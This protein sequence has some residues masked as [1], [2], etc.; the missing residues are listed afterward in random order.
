MIDRI[1]VSE[2]TLSTIE[3][4]GQN[5][6]T[7]VSGKPDDHLCVEFVRAAPTPTVASD[8]A[9]PT[10]VGKNALVLTG[11]Q[12]LEALDFIAPDRATDPEQLEA[13][14]AIEFGE[15]HGGKAMYVW[16][17]EYPEEGSFV[18]DGKPA[19]GELMPINAPALQPAEREASDE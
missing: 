3:R 5:N 10:Q 6:L 16:C 15:G 2:A 4:Y 14:V 7:N 17:A 19:S 8:A 11:A 12:L 18:L 1:Y 13:T 9:A